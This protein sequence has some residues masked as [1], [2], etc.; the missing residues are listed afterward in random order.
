MK[1]NPSWW[2]QKYLAIKIPKKLPLNKD[3]IEQIFNEI[4][5]DGYLL[6]AAQRLNASNPH[7]AMY[8]L[9]G[10]PHSDDRE[11]KQQT[12]DALDSLT[13]ENYPEAIKK[14]EHILDTLTLSPT[15]KMVIFLNLGNA[16]FTIGQFD[17]ALEK[18]KT[19]LD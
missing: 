14:L 19:I 12:A 5:L 16:Y 18:Y 4:A 6:I 9:D 13:K 3:N 17:K 7:G 11:L 2:T 15:E 10:I 8:F 1:Q